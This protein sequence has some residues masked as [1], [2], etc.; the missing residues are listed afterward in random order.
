MA[1]NK[2][3]VNRY[4]CLTVFI[5]ASVLMLCCEIFK[6]KFLAIGDN[7]ELIYSITSRFFG[8]ALC[9]VLVLYC[10]FARI[11]KLVR[12]PF[13]KG[14]IAVLPC[15]V[16]A[17]NNFPIIPVALGQ[18]RV[19][20][21]AEN[22]L[23]YALLCAFVGVFEELAYRGC[24]FMLIL[25]GSRRSAKDIIKAI[26]ISSALFG[27]IHLVNLIVGADPLGVILQ[28]GYSFLIGAMCSFVL[29][30]TG[31]VWHC[32]LMHAVYNFCGGVVA[33]YGEGS[34]WT[35]P[36]VALTAVVG[37]I[38]ALYVFFALLK[39]EPSEAE[40]LF[41]NSENEVSYGNV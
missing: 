28:I 1:D 26:V 20:D 10:G 15:W 19:T 31:S 17:L 12:A 5:L 30:K 38:V 34:I 36:E 32:A 3:T 40:R 29:I 13:F 14:L 27:A 22:I 23:L 4:L 2:K 37:V 16:V 21:K 35:L 25:K 39:T 11:L 7:G 9:L 24:V 41:V 18:A 6:E 33:N 8:I